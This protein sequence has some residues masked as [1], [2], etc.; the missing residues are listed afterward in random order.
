MCITLIVYVCTCLLILLCHGGICLVILN[1]LWGIGSIELHMSVC[2]CL[3]IS[4]DSRLV[5]IDNFY[6]V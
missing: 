2:V 4:D 1:C 6:I 3:S 5:R